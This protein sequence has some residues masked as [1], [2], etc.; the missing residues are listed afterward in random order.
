MD[1]VHRNKFN[2]LSIEEKLHIAKQFVI[3]EYEKTFGLQNAFN[4]SIENYTLEPGIRK[5]K[6]L[7]YIIIGEINL[8]IL[9]C[10]NNKTFPIDITYEDVQT[11]YL[12]DKYPIVKQLIHT[13]D[14]VGIM[15]SLFAAS[16][17]HSDV[18]AATSKFVYSDKMFDL[19]LTGLLD[20]MMK[21]SFQISFTIAYN[22]LS[23]EC[24]EKLNKRHTESKDVGIHMHM[25]DGSINKSGTSAGIAITIL[26]YSLL[27]NRK[28][29]H[30]YATTG[31]ASD[32]NGK[33]GEI[34]ALRYKF[35][36][37]IKAG[38]KHLIFP[39]NNSHEY[40]EFIEKYKNN[41]FI[42][43][44]TFHPVSHIIQVIELIVI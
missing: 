27:S 23:A 18:L 20:D 16:S 30:D 3:P 40:H 21:E 42:D 37:G 13:E 12:S 7:L 24:K 29:R 22:V 44:V 34:G 35:I 4:F 38:V 19:N 10:K 8:E 32:L 5:F 39:E 15:N 28:I 11:K 17:G 36:G 2:S 6:E 41:P 43:G 14:E 9:N 1:H 33:V 31:E 25:G 26:L